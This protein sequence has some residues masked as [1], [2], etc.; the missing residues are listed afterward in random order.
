MTVLFLDVLILDE[1]YPAR[2]LVYKARRLRVT[3]SNWSLHARFEEW[4]VTFKE[5]FHKF[6]VRPF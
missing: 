6:G 1:S 3:T 5:I 2:L 4:D